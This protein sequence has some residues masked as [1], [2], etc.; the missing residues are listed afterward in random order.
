MIHLKFLTYFFTKPQAP[1]LI[2]VACAGLL[3]FKY[4]DYQSIKQAL[5]DCQ[6]TRPVEQAAKPA[7]VAKESYQV[8]KKFNETK[9]RIIKEVVIVEKEVACE[10]AMDFLRSEALK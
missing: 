2:A 5:K 4:D 3:Y 9:E 8:A 6:A 10:Q 7:E 1:W